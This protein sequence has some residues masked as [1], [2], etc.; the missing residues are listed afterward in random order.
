[1]GSEDFDWGW[2]R[3][4]WAT[5]PDA[6]AFL[7]GLVDEFTTQQD[8][9]GAMSGSIEWGTS[10]KFIDW[11]DHMVLPEDSVDETELLFM[12]F[13]ED[14][15]AETMYG[16]RCF[17]HR[18]STLFPILLRQGNLTELAIKV[19]DLDTF[20]DKH[21]RQAEIL[22]DPFAPYRW[23]EVAR[24]H[25]HLLIA[26]ERRGY[27]GFALE[28]VYDIDEYVNALNAFRERRREFPDDAE[29]LDF[30]Y[31]LVRAQLEDLATRRVADAWFRAE[32]EYWESTNQAG[33][34]QKAR[35][36]ALGLGWANHDHQAYRCSRDHYTRVID[37]LELF[38]LRRRE[39]YYAGHQAGWGAQVMENPVGPFVVFCDVDMAPDEE[40]IDFASEGFSPR[41]ELGTIGLWVALHGESML[42]AGIHHVAFRFQFERIVQDMNSRGF[43]VMPPFSQFPELKQCFTVAD[44]WAVDQVRAKDLLDR[45]LIDEEQYNTF[46][47]IGGI[48]SHVELIERSEGYKGF[49]QDSVSA[50]IEATDPRGQ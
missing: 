41:D 20:R 28:D 11:I 10:T 6:E 9:A 17:R 34:A 27:G 36:D 24:E 29:G 7:L 38:G 35:Q 21:I 40:D 18:G 19:D 25:Q 16:A 49:N 23:L 31:E 26:I 1:M 48:G 50:I 14:G 42:Q 8:R 43:S 30:T 4:N 33:Q 12:G 47:E 22:A 44:P 45:G 2:D 13:V 5:F 39:A 15:S 3:F 46:G 32:R 37:I